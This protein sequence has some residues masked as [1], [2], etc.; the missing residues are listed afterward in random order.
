MTF[1]SIA[2]Q[3]GL[4]QRARDLEKNQD[5]VCRN[6]ENPYCEVCFE[7]HVVNYNWEKKEL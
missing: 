3:I 1:Q 6:C 2:V 4:S 5:Y 7:R